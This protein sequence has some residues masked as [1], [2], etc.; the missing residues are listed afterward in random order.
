MKLDKFSHVVTAFA[1][2]NREPGK[3]PLICVVIR[4]GDGKLSIEYLQ[5]EEWPKAAAYIFGASAQI[6]GQ[7]TGIIERAMK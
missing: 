3:V 5:E 2:A 4:D 1:E 6:S 7:M